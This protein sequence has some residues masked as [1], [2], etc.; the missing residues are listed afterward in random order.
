MMTSAVITDHATLLA[1]VDEFRPVFRD[2]H[3]DVGLTDLAD[4][5]IDL[6]CGD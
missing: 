2:E 1:P 3:H 4:L 6:G 5:W